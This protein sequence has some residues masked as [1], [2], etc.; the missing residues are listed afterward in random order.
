MNHPR[1]IRR[2]RGQIKVSVRPI[3]RHNAANLTD[4]GGPMVLTIES[5]VSSLLDQEAA[6]DQ[7]V[8][9]RAVEDSDR[10]SRR[11][12]DRLVEAIE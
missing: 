2:L 12:D 9:A 5:N 11:A 4:P 7:H 3:A 8:E 6:E 1:A 10:V